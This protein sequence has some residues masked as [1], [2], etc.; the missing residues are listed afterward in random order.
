MLLFLMG[1]LMMVRSDLPVGSAPAPVTARHFP[2]RLHAYIWR[3]WS[4]VPMARLAQ[5]V[6]AKPSEI[7]AIGR[8]MGL[9]EPL[10]ISAMQ[11][12]RSYLTVLRRNW[13]LL[14]YP[15]LLQLL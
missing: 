10:A 5:V 11:Q 7:V 12:R 14:P 1:V 2:D 3:N 6:G 15:Q 9:S 13:H 8:A 4:L